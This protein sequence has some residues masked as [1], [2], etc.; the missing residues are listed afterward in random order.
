MA[1]INILIDGSTQ[2]S[3]P[4]VNNG[5]NNVIIHIPKCVLRRK[6][7]RKHDVERLSVR[8]GKKKKE[9]QRFK[10]YFSARKYT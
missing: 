5:T 8:V 7:Q 10:L 9:K 1:N 2:V 4:F 6:S 3:L